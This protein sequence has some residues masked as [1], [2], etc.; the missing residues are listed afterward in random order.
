MSDDNEV[1]NYL[2]FQFK[3]IWRKVQEL[4]LVKAYMVDEQIRDFI[5]MIDAIPFLPTDR[6]GEIF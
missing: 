1:D 5:K 4:G 3:A 2:S 6:I